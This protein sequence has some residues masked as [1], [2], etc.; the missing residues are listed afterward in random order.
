MAGF[1]QHLRQRK[2][3]PAAGV[4][5]VIAVIAFVVGLCIWANRS[6]PGDRLVVAGPGYRL[7]WRPLPPAAERV[8]K[9]L[10][11]ST[12]VACFRISMKPHHKCHVT[13]WRE[14]WD[15]KSSKGPISVKIVSSLQ[16]RSSANITIVASGRFYPFT[17]VDVSWRTKGGSG[18]TYNFDPSRP[19]HKRGES[20]LFTNDGRM[21]LNAQTLPRLFPAAWRGKVQETPV[22]DESWASG[23]ITQ[24]PQFIENPAKNPIILGLGLPKGTKPPSNQH[25]A[26]TYLQIS[27]GAS[28]PPQPTLRN[29]RLVFVSQ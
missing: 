10:G 6:H 25:E 20:Y 26:V 9:T 22:F 29:G 28:H 17:L 3:L 27:A 23:A 1:L 2:K 4:A 13:V 18:E 11:I 16:T 15:S 19:K 12:K 14:T 7:W 5:A 8:L 21:N 24:S